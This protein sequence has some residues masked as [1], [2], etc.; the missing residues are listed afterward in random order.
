MLGSFCQVRDNRLWILVSG[1]PCLGYCQP[2]DWLK[3]TETWF[4]KAS[5]DR[6]ERD[7]RAPDS[8]YGCYG[9]D[10]KPTHWQPLPEP[11]KP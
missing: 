10:V 6:R 3:K 11:P 1:Q 4:A 8:I 7:G 5:F 9:V 2:A